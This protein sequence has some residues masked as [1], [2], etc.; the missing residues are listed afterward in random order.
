[1]IKR[2]ELIIIAVIRPP[3]CSPAIIAKPIRAGMDAAWR[4][5]SHSER[6][7]HSAS[8]TEQA[9]TYLAPFPPDMHISSM[10]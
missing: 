6:N 3:S 4:N 7:G 1:M 10:D 2:T 9:E 5:D 8:I